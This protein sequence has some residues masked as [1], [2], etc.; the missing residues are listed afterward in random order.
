MQYHYGPNNY[1]FVERPER[2]EKST[3]QMAEPA[4]RKTRQH[5]AI[6]DFLASSDAFMSAQHIHAQL[7]SRGE[8]IGLATV[9]R[10]LQRMLADGDVDVV[11]VE[12]AEAAYRACAADNHHH[13]LVCRSCGTAHEI[14][15]PNFERWVA[16]LATEYQFSELDHT[17]EVHGLCAQCTD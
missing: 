9:Y 11:R 17:V 10:V 14:L 7:R 3:Q 15:M 1:S 2:S 13:H 4:R 5:A 8:T 16:G 6:A 12:G